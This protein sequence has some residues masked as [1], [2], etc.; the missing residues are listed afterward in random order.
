MAKCTV[1][2]KTRYK[3]ECVE[4]IDSMKDVM[5]SDFMDYYNSLNP[6]EYGYGPNKSEEIWK[7]WLEENV[8]FKLTTKETNEQSN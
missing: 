2:V 7:E 3:G 8:T 5:H 1:D 4:D 6:P